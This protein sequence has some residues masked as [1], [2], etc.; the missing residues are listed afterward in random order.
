M[1][2]GYWNCVYIYIWYTDI[3]R[4]DTPLTYMQHCSSNEDWI[5]LFQSSTPKHSWI[6]L[7]FPLTIGAGFSLFAKWDESSSMYKGKGRRRWWLNF[8][9]KLLAISNE[10]WNIIQAGWSCLFPFFFQ[11]EW[12]WNQSWRY[13]RYWTIYKWMNFRRWKHAW[14]TLCK[15]LPCDLF[16]NLKSTWGAWMQ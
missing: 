4:R 11:L 13:V 9:T 16:A 3:P 6:Y 8:S 5:S 1:K 15:R 10:A 14:W 12:R 7:S 2:E